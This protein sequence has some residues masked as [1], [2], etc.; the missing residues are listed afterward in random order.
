MEGVILAMGAAAE[1]GGRFATKARE[2]A[3]KEE[4]G[5]RK[6]ELLKIAEV[7][8]RVPAHPAR[9]FHEAIQSYYLS[10]NDEEAF[11]F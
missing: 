7:C 9:T 5:K 1:V 3:N 10:C 6:A 2:L 11:F 8:D 4:N